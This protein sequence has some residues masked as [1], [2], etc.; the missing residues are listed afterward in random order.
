MKRIFIHLP[1]FD[2][3]WKK[4]GLADEELK[5]LQE[6]LLENP[7]YGP[8]IKGSNGIRKIRWRKKG[9]GKS[10]GIRVFYLDIEELSVLFLITLLEKNDKENLSKKELTILSDLV[11]SLKE[12][13]QSKRARHEKRK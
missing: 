8:V 7:K 13:I 11:T 1:D 3:F 12:V 6:F 10:G 5:E 9:I 2:L 4:A